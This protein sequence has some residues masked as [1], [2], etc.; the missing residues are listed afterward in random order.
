MA[1]SH[2]TRELLRAVARGDVA[3]RILDEIGTSH[4]MTLCDHCREE[5]EAF[6]KEEMGDAAGNGY[7]AAMVTMELVLLYLRQDRTADV[8]RA[9]EE[10]VPIFHAQDVHREALAALVLFQDAARREELTV[11][12]V[13]EIAAYL[14]EARGNPGL[15]FHQK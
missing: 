1:D 7:D 9:A 8:K 4:L 11:R 3:P 5:I 10:M 12:K 15:R 6:R 2:L 13:H 14:R